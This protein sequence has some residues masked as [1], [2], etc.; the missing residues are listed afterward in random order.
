MI[1]RNVHTTKVIDSIRHQLESPERWNEVKDKLHE[2]LQLE[3]TRRAVFLAEMGATDSD[4]RSELESLIAFHEQTGTDFLN[5][6]VPATSVIPPQDGHEEFL[7]QRVGS[8]QIAGLIGIGG[9]GEV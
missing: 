3:P 1:P 9:M 6:W 5:T 2:A 7:G 4:L 8:Y